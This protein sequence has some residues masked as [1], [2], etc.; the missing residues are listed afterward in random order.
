MIQNYTIIANQEINNANIGEGTII[1]SPV[2]IYGCTIGEDNKIGKF[3][4]I[5][6]GAVIGNKNKISTH[7]HIAGDVIIGSGNFIGH[8]VVI[9]DTKLPY[10]IDKDGEVIKPEEVRTNT[11]KIGDCNIIGSGA[12]ILPGVTIGN[13]CI[14]GAGAIVTKDVPDFTVVKNKLNTVHESIVK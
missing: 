14:I 8:N 11:V 9:A 7:T 6:S 12:I 2:S 4:E 13:D 1:Y 10:A 3:T 5:Q